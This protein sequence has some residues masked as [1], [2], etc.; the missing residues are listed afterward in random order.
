M[1]NI[2]KAI[3]LP[4]GVAGA[5]LLGAYGSAR[6]SYQPQPP[7]PG[8]ADL[9]EWVWHFNDP[10]AISLAFLSLIT[11][12]LSIYGA[13]TALTKKDVSL[14]VE[15]DGNITRDLLKLCNNQI[16]DA[17]NSQSPPPRKAL[18][19]IVQA[20]K[21]GIL[22]ADEIASLRGAILESVFQEYSPPS[23]VFDKLKNAIFANENNELIIDSLRDMGGEDR[24][25]IISGRLKEIESSENDL[26]DKYYRLAIFAAIDDPLLAIQFYRKAL[27]HAPS[28]V[29]VANALGQ[30][31]LRYGTTS[32][33]RECFESALSSATEQYQR[34]ELAFGLAT[35]SH[36]EGKNDTA[37]AI[38]KDALSIAE[39]QAIENA[40][41]PF[42]LHKII[43]LYLELAA[44]QIDQGPARSAAQA[45]DGCFAG[46]NRLSA[47]GHTCEAAEQSRAAAHDCRGRLRLK[48]G[49]AVGA[50]EDF[51]NAIA[52]RGALISQNPS[53]FNSQRGL[54]VANQQATIAHIAR[55]DLL[56]AEK[57]L[58][59][60]HSI[61]A[62]LVQ[63]FP[64]NKLYARDR[65][66]VTMKQADLHLHQGNHE[67]VDHALE[68]EEKSIRGSIEV[69]GTDSQMQRDLS[70]ILERRGDIAK[71]SGE[72]LNGIE[73]YKEAL[74]IRSAIYEK[75]Q[76]N[77]LLKKDI[78]IIRSKIGAIEIIQSNHEEAI[79]QLNEAQNIY[80]ELEDAK[81]PESLFN[82]FD[83]TQ[84]IGDALWQAGFRNDA[85]DLYKDA[86][87]QIDALQCQ[88]PD[89]SSY[90]V[91]SQE[92]ADRIAR[93]SA[94]IVP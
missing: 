66:I 68:A 5:S 86:Q 21:E 46:L 26:S 24:S 40:S 55:G 82:V 34:V 92:I 70:V 32:E 43:S 87:A 51:E 10:V 67:K 2:G 39:G 28:N 7:V 93:R 69:D 1:A 19:V 77:K 52:I 45:L 18:D 78:A 83:V 4:M 80:L 35:T 58:S 44:I 36:L 12:F 6:S 84:L 81:D 29:Q 3:F 48:A 65:Y 27:T 33:A 56:E 89:I 85:I 71:A 50:L 42:W 15:N 9:T 16:L 38:L 8:L 31:L 53:D 37:K 62:Q 30:L 64:N 49:D 76:S 60:A 17:I 63:R 74:I 94:P 59:A 75:D 47:I 72:S 11:T 57:S 22:D 14:I 23:D 25:K 90:S 13:F 91:W 41:D 79:E 88:F 61:A 20:L 54:G 73:K